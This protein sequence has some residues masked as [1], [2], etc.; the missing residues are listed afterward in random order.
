[1]TLQTIK[2]EIDRLFVDAVAE[3]MQSMV[4]V[5][6]TIDRAAS[7]EPQDAELWGVV[8]LSGTINGQVAVA[9]SREFGKRHVGQVMGMETSDVDEEILLDGVGEIANIIAGNANGKLSQMGFELKVSLPSAVTAACR[10]DPQR[11]DWSMNY[12]V[13]SHLGRYAM[14]VWLATT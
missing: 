5:E 11:G 13:D 1:V 3:F 7:A 10:R 8:T 6:C 2:H 4:G 14:S 9:F 12:E